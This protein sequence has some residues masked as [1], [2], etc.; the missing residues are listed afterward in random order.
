MTNVLMFLLSD[1]PKSHFCPECY[2]YPTRVCVCGGGGGGRG[3]GGWGVAPVSAL[4]D[5]YMHI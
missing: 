3:G 1:Y 2:D 5:I 4:T